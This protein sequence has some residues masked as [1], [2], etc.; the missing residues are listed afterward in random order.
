VR[1]VDDKPGR[2][3]LG[4]YFSISRFNIVKFKRAYE[5]SPRPFN[6]ATVFVY[7]GAGDLL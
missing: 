6:S 4:R 1:I 5:E 2:I 3:H 7:T